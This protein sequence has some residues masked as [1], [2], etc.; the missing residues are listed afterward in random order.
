MADCHAWKRNIRAAALFEEAAMVMARAEQWRPEIFD[1]AWASPAVKT[2]AR[3]A[4][5]VAGR[6]GRLQF[7]RML[8]LNGIPWS[9]RLKYA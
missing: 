2:S 3:R 1:A 9:N 8:A 5:A 4:C 6:N 7:L